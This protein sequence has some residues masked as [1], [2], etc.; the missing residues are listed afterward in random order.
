M[1][2]SGDGEGGENELEEV[3]HLCSELGVKW[4]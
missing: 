3:H 1:L 4:K 2:T